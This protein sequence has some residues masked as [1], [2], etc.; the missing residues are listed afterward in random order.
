ML[1]LNEGIFPARTE[2]EGFF[3]DLEKQALREMGLELSPDSTQQLY[4][5]QF[6]VYLAL[7]RASDYLS[8]SYSLADEDGKALRPSGIV[9]KL[10]RLYPRLAQ[11]PVQWPP[12]EG[13]ALLPYLNH[14][15]KAMGLLGSHL[16]AA[17]PA[18]AAGAM[19]R[20]V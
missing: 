15:G 8:L 4:D 7:T 10:R 20:A 13:Q 12:G 2:Q 1:G 19:G 17:Q 18:G 3:N 6:L 16:H 9:D 11:Q 14:P 5:E